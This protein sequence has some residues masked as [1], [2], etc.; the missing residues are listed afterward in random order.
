[1]F[2][3][4]LAVLKNTVLIALIVC[5][6]FGKAQK[7]FKIQKDTLPYNKKKEIVFDDKRYRVWNNYLTFGA[8][9]GYSDIR[10]I[11]QSVLNVDF[12]FHL[13]KQYFQMGFFMSGN[14]FLRNTDL[15]GH[16]CYGFRKEKNYVN[17]AAYVGPSYSY[18]V[19]GVVDTSGY[20]KVTPH[21]ALGGYLCLQAIYK[22]KYDVG[23]GLELFADISDQQKIAGIR[24]VAYFS[25]AYR[26]ERRGY[27]P[28]KKR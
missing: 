28:P 20:V 9:K 14:R 27:K 12:Q 24:L 26:G 8:G 1:L 11:D 22:F 19:T 15:S 7:F 23:I 6:S 4:K 16:L 13:Q 2:V 10:N 3:R 25:G 18:F 21:A 5:I 17:W